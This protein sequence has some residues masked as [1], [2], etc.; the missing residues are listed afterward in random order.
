[1]AAVAKTGPGHPGMPIG[2]TDTILFGD[3]RNSGISACR[4]IE[5]TGAGLD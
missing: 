1:M 4:I 3:L 5:P 2:T